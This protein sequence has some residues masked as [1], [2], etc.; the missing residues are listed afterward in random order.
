MTSARFR[1]HPF[2]LRQLQYVVA[3][4]HTGG[5]GSAAQACGVSQ[6]SL[7]AQ[8][9]KVE[10]ALGV[11]LFERTPRAIRLTPE[12]QALLPELLRLLAQCDDLVEHAGELRDPDTA[13]LRIGVIPTVAPYLLP[14][15]VRS[16]GKGLPKL[17]VHWIEAQTAEV[18]AALAARELDAGIIADPPSLAGMVERE[19]GRD[20]FLLLVSDQDPKLERRAK[21]SDLAG[22]ALLLLADGHCLRDHA[23]DVCMRE[24]AIESPYRATSLSTL[25]QMVGAGLG[26]TLL[27]SSAL[28]VESA[29]APVRAV[30]FREPAPGRTLR[31]VWP[32][33]A[34]RAPL[35]ERVAE[36]L[37]AAFRGR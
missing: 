6:P 21:P 19:I 22:R 16:L 25:V 26:V 33:H 34:R 28:A 7:S 35:L 36:R 14:A 31:L 5:F 12:G 27:P 9:A 1:D 8:V 4:A 24:G 20:R 10:D 23:M 32:E 29:R 3:V 30:P 18:E 15:A 37:A 17:T 11:P 13:T 2:T